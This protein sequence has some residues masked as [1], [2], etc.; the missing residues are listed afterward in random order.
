[1]STPA[2]H[3]ATDEPL[4]VVKFPD[5]VGLPYD[6]DVVDNLPS[7]GAVPWGPIAAAFPGVS[8]RRMFTSVPI[9]RI[10]ELVDIA[11]S[12]EQKYEPPD[13]SSFFVV[14]VGQSW[15]VASLISALRS[16]L[17]GTVVYYDPPG[18]D[19]TGTLASNPLFTSQGYLNPAPE[20]V[21]AIFAWTV[22]G[23]RGTGQD[24]VDMEKGWTLNHEDIVAHAT[25]ILDGDIQDGARRHGTAVLGAVCAEDNTT[26]VVGVAPDPSNVHV[27]SYYNS[28][29]PNAIMAAIDALPYGGILLLEAQLPQLDNGTDTFYRLPIEVQLADFEAI[30]LATA[31]GITVI[32]AGGNGPNDLSDVTDSNGNYV[33]R[34][35]HTDYRDS[36]AILIGAA[37]SQPPHEPVPTTNRGA[38]VNCYA[39][40][41]NVVTA[42]TTTSP[43][44][45][46]DTYQN[47][48]ERTS[49]AAAIVAGTAL[50]VQG[51]AENGPGGYRLNA[52]QMRHLLSDE[53]NGTPS[54]DPLTDGIGVMPDLRKIINNNKIA[55]APDVYVRDY[56]GDVG[57]THTGV[58]SASPDIILRPITVADPQAAYGEGSGTESNNVLGHE[59]TA[60]QDNHIYVRVRNRGGSAATN[61]SVEVFWAPVAALVTPDLWTRIG[62]AT[63]PAVPPGG[64]LTVFDEITWSAA[65]IPAA[66]HY[67]FIGIVGSAEDPAPTI[68]ADI[69]W[70][71]FR[72][73]IRDNN[74]VTWRNF[75]VVDIEPDP[76]IGIT[77][78]EFAA[79]DFMVPGAPDGQQQMQID[80][81][82]QL[83]EDSRVMLEVPRAMYDQMAYRLPFR[84]EDV[85][86]SK[87]SIRFAMNPHGLRTLGD[88]EIP[89]RARFELRLL[90]HVPKRFHKNSYEVYVR[91]V[92]DDLEVGRVTW[93]LSPERHVDPSEKDNP[94]TRGRVMKLISKVTKVLQNHN[95]GDDQIAIVAKAISDNFPPRV[96]FIAVW[97]I[98]VI[99]LSMALG[100]VALLFKGISDEA[101]WVAIGVGLGALAGIFAGKE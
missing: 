4:V 11:T 69:A 35:G 48:F 74:N 81:G 24:F 54:K 28:N 38:R 3:V 55:V 20:G 63:L 77:P 31:V 45:K 99:T 73:I 46:T 14:D 12:N 32:A 30:R 80:V 66:G 27:T 18:E 9:Q 40:G 25:D 21:D 33:L 90:V 58:I 2:S 91:Q 76:D 87:K 78:P 64:L 94:T 86:V 5:Q 43:P 95:F 100:A 16:L 6:D 75:N 96:Y 47:S 84:P 68:P 83:P 44:F 59:A 71:D 57:Q 34:P 10:R 70:E 85:D 60:G 41:E 56:V 101:V 79:M 65:N 29:R 72:R 98:G 82:A 49:S 26:G 97:F 7:V 19:P 37:T 1:M 22:A 93:R 23:G 8:M 88:I 13:F 53:A 51:I 39:W 52:Y 61:V 62:N 50:V 17:P 89:Q 36:G 67:C 42:D 92:Q 15:D